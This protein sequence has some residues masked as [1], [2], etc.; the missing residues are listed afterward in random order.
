MKE[1]KGNGLALKPTDG[2]QFFK[3]T[4]PASLFKVL[5]KKVD[6]SKLGKDCKRL[7][8]T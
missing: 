8:T 3:L 1:I 2:D 5:Q 7:Q 4:E 6:K